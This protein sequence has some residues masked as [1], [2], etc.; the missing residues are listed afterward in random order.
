MESALSGI[1]ILDFSR[2]QAGP[3]AT[4]MLSDMGAEVI[5]VEE[6]R[7]EPG[8]ATGMGPDG[9]SAMYEANNR[10]K[11][12][13]TVNLHSDEGR[14]IVRRILPT[15]DIVLENFRPGTMEHW[16][17]GYEDLKQMKSDIIFASISA[18]GREGP[19]G[20]RAGYDHVAQALSGVMY[21]QGGGPDQE[22]HAL[23]GGFADSIGAMS[24]AFGVVCA[25]QAR[26]RTGR[27]QH[28]DSSLIGAMAALQSLPLIRF[29]RTGEQPGFQYRRSATYTHYRCADDR[30]I[31]IAA[32]TQA[33]WERFCD[34]ARPA[35][36]DDPRFKGPFERNDNKEDLVA[37]LEELFLE[38]GCVEWEE[39]LTVA[40]V[41]NAPVLDYAGVA[42]HPQFYANGYI[43]EIDHPNLGKMR[44]VG[45][46]VRMS[47]TPT[48]IQGAGPELGQHTEEV[49][50]TL[51]Y[52][53]DQISKLRE[54]GAI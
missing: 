54:N 5:K 28:V 39:L 13:I 36:R 26:S 14:E 21:E 32:N 8:R 11:K 18:W 51:G 9:F 23:I 43:Q 24:L 35:L 12:S 27:G 38:R 53:W 6:P 1:R 2:Y 48:R 22:P 40:D 4:V 3:F 25:L 44:V 10:G 45:P 41:P 16:G 20:R 19:W 52:T 37:T 34:A 50:L 30:Y 47:D 33:F 29:L 17:L 7:S 49:L 42:A 46:A 31:A 15:C